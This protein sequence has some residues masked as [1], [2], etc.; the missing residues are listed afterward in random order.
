MKNEDYRIPRTLDDPKMFL[1]F[2]FDTA[3]VFLIVFMLTIAF[4]IVIALLL[5]L[6]AAKIYIQL[7]ENGDRGLV[8]HLVYWYLPS[9]LW[10]SP[11]WP[12][13][14]REFGGR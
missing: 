9:D 11:Y 10:L 1:F 5:S 4:S 8:K 2:R 3:M 13:A 6:M 12:S 14:E 7:R